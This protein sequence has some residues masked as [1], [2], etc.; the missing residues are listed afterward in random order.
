M[1]NRN[2]ERIRND[3]LSDQI[4]KKTWKRILRIE[5][6]KKRYVQEEDK[7]WR[8]SLGFLHQN[9]RNGLEGNRS[10]HEESV[11]VTDVRNEFRQDLKR[12]L[13]E[14]ELIR[15]KQLE[16]TKKRKENRKEKGKSKSINQT[17]K[18]ILNPCNF[19][20][21]IFFFLQVKL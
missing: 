10:S 3:Y 18:Q 11:V 20:N 17:T 4:R 7:R 12:R 1:S 8:S 14:A 9:K 2:L 21:S 13:Q 19:Q 15:N 16:N 5:K 6:S